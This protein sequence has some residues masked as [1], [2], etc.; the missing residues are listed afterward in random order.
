[1]TFQWPE[2]LAAAA[3]IPALIGLY[4]WG[5]RRRRPVAARYSSL[6]LI[7]DAA[8]PRA[9]W[10]RHVPFSLLIAAIA[11]LVI[12]IARPTAFVS[13]P[14][15]Q[16]TILLALDVS[17]SMCSTDISPSRLEAAQEAAS[18]FVNGQP[19]GTQIGIVAFSSFAAV[20]QAPTS[21]RDGLLKAIRS[22][23]TGRGTAV[24]SGILAAIDSIAQ[25]D[26]S[27]APSVMEGRPGVAPEP[28]LPGV[29]APDII[30]VL[31]DGASNTGVDPLDAAQQAADRGLRVYT[32]GFGTEG[33]GDGSGCPQAFVGREPAT[34]PFG[35]GGAGAAPGGFP[36]GIDEDTLKS[37]AELTG[38]TYS[39]AESVGELEQVFA[40]LPTKLITRQGTMELTVAFVALGSLLA[41]AALLLARAW[42][43]L[44]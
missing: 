5:R 1:M 24:G 33:G 39:P 19:S 15:N 31:T 35:G 36:R 32:I 28:V 20:I 34:G 23:T 42:R 29:Y 22:L 40:D 6:S 18:A 12:A 41:G 38:G 11:A 2:L 25:V 3:V 17:S 44:P 7:R 43:P 13:I 4:V 27:V 37:I 26:D 9:R 30:V 8:P 14:A 16:A 10:R 21:D